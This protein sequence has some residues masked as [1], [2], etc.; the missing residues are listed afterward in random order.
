MRLRNAHT[1]SRT[2]LGVALLL[3]ALWPLA[4]EVSAL[5]SLVAINVVLWPMIAWETAHYGDGRYR[6][7]HGLEFEPPGSS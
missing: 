4:T 2:R 7:R 6:L 5:V 1:I 3:F